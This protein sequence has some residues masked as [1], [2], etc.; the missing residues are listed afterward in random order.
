MF[1]CYEFGKSVRLD[2]A[3]IETYEDSGLYIYHR[4]SDREVTKVIS[5]ASTLVINPVEPVTQPKEITHYL[6]VE[7]KKPIS[8]APLSHLVFFLTFPVEIGIYVSVKK[9]MEHIDSFTLT[10]PKYTLYG[11]PH[12]GLVCKFWESDIYSNIPDVKP[13]HEGVMKVDL[14][15]TSNNWTELKKIVFDAYYMKIFY[16]KFASMSTVVKIYGNQARTSF[17]EEPLLG[18][19]KKA[20]E[21]LRL[22]K[23]PG[24]EKREFL[25][26]LGL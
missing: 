26:E 14:Q 10:N 7:I 21:L 23:I 19:M 2:T 1:G 20:V 16:S 17:K 11:I 22:K 13:Y 6:L 12:K 18:D 5:S 25:M 8:L 9:N 15:N 3:E 4:K 24:V